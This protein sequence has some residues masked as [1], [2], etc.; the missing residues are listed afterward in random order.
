MN[1]QI[2]LYEQ[3]F[4]SV[5]N[6]KIIEVNQC[7]KRYIAF[8]TYKK[9]TQMMVRFGQ[10]GAF[11]YFD[12]ASEKKQKSYKARASKITNKYGIFTYKKAGTANSFAYWIL[13]N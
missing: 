10:I 7:G 12:G 1:K 2:Q 8:F 13:W 6:L 9:T 5:T 4:P 3:R 11:T